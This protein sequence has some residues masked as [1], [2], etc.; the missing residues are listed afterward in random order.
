MAVLVEKNS[1][2]QAEIPLH[3]QQEVLQLVNVLVHW[4]EGKV[5]PCVRARV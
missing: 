2:A 5:R 3:K 1:L 4:K